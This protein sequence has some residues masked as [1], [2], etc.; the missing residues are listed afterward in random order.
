MHGEGQQVKRDPVLHAQA[1]QHAVRAAQAAVAGMRALNDEER[2]AVQE[3][4]LDMPLPFVQ[5]YLQEVGGRLG[6]RGGLPLQV[7]PCERGRES[8]R[9]RR[10]SK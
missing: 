4:K 1:E 9:G 6:T 8:G 2:R 7:G 10:E 3:G 5:Y